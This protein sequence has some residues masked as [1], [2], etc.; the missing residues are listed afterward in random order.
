MKKSGRSNSK[1]RRREKEKGRIAVEK[2]RAHEKEIAKARRKKLVERL[3]SGHLTFR[4]HSTQERCLALEAP[5]SEQ[6]KIRK[7]DVIIDQ[8][9][10]P[11][12]E[13][14]EYQLE[15]DPKWT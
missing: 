8:H 3:R 11:Y 12:K 13:P 10:N 14:N 4:K 7:K 6:Q 2:L 1:N 5:F 15:G 9:T